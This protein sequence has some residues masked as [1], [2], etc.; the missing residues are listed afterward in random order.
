[1]AA[2]VAQPSGNSRSNRILEAAPDTLG[3]V[4][5]AV[6]SWAWYQSGTHVT[7]DT[8]TLFWSDPSFSHSFRLEGSAG[9]LGAPIACW[10]AQHIFRFNTAAGRPA[11]RSSGSGG[12]SCDLS[13][14][15]N[16]GH[17]VAWTMMVPWGTCCVIYCLLLLTYKRDKARLLEQR[18][19]KTTPLLQ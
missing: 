15:H 3:R 9:A 6:V 7:Q 4:S 18:L 11:A 8:L 12:E 1:M 14:A 19:E 13:N 16:L 10:V 5:G 2:E 17:A